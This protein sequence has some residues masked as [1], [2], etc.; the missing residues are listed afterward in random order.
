MGK[1]SSLS[2][3]DAVGPQSRSQVHPVFYEHLVAGDFDNLT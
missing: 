3:G 1:A 2:V